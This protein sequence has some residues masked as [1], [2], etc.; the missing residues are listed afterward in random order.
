[1][2]KAYTDLKRGNRQIVPTE[3][4]YHCLDTLRQDLMCLADDTPMPTPYA[5]HHVGNGQIRQCRDWRRL[6][7]WTQ[8]PERHACYRML[9]DYRKVPHTLEQ[10]A[11]CHEGSEYAPIAKKYF[12]DNGH[13]NPYGD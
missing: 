5:I 10:F 4:F 13:Q 9:D 12:E 7:E 8:E 2:R 11:Y 1:M 6:V 3:H